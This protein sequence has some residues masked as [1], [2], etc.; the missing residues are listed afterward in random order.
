ME[1]TRNII[2][3]TTAVAWL[4]ASWCFGL[5]IPGIITGVSALGTACHF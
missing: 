4:L 3:A 1:P 2:I 5:A